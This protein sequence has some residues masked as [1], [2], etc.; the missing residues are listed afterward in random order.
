MNKKNVSLIVLMFVCTSSASLGLADSRKHAHHAKNAVPAVCTKPGALPSL[1]CA[2]APNAVFDNNGRLWLAWASD[3]HVYVNYSDDKGKTF[4]KPVAV[5][6]IPEVIAA[7]GENRP[8]VAINQKGYVYVSWTQRLKKRFSGH[9]R[10]SRSIDHGEHFSDP[11]TVNDHREV[12]SHRFEAL[13]INK[14]G[15]IYLAWLDKRD[16]LKAESSGRKYRG[17]ALY[18][19]L[20]RDNGRTFE[21]NKKIQDH[22]CECCR[23]VMAIDTD[24]LPVILWRHIFGKNT[25]DH[26]LVKFT[27]RNQPGKPVRVSHDNWQVDGC[28][29]HG[30]AISVADDGVY[31]LAWFNNA[32]DRHG[33]FYAHSSDKGQT[34]ST[35]VRFGNYN[36]S[37]AHPQVLSKGELVFLAWKEFDG[38]QSK[39]YYKKSTDGGLQWSAP[40]L[41]AK[42]S[43]A[44]DHPLLISDKHTVYAAWHRRGEDYRLIPITTLTHSH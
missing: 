12:T 15:D 26:A 21:P 32:P 10:F 23:V 9:I 5:N 33:L 40:L 22:S 20:S 24:Q 38:K 27:S 3:G 6:R 44:T 14:K 29:H 11:V 19:A 42:S 7:R 25:R 8:K 31:H 36:K 18:F 39:L 2:R 17:A 35:P 13:G 30:P 28:P 41:L 16:K 1:S 37:A 34:F 43:S 4:S